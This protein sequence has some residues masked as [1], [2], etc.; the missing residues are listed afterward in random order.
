MLP[1]LGAL[2]HPSTDP[3]VERDES[4]ELIDMDDPNSTGVLP[5]RAKKR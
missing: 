5:D 4:F 3:V 2:K 1:S